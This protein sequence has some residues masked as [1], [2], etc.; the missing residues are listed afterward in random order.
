MDRFEPSLDSPNKSWA[1]RLQALFEVLL[2]SGLASSFLASLPFSAVR[3]R[4]AELLLNDVRIVSAFVLLEAGITLLLLALVLRA[5]RERLYDLGLRRRE[6]RPNI[7]I[8]LMLVPL[9]FSA[10]AI[11][12]SAFR[13]YLPKYFSNRN[14]LTEIIRTPQQLG[15][16]IFSAL[17][18]GGI[19]EE[20]Q[21]AFI[22]TRFRQYLGG[23]RLGLMLWSVAFG[24]GHYIQGMQGVVIA[25]VFGFVFGTV[26]LIRGTLIAPM[27]AH[28]IYDTLALLA[29]WFYR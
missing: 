12:S 24:A 22:L 8:G 29:Y 25:A 6:W 28:G 3:A 17:V 10:N 16:F 1:D 11:I 9:L 2:L 14:P 13:V 21:R 26:Y 23:E 5:R 20:L 7:V 4:G 19:K 27:V 18:A 15:L